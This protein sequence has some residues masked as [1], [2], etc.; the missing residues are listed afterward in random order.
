MSTKGLKG[1]IQSRGSEVSTVCLWFPSEYVSYSESDMER[2]GMGM[3]EWESLAFCHILRTMSIKGFV[4]EWQICTAAGYANR[5]GIGPDLTGWRRREQRK[6]RLHCLRG[7]IWEAWH[8][9]LTHIEREDAHWLAFGILQLQGLL[10]L[11]VKF[12]NGQTS[13]QHHPANRSLQP[14]HLL[15]RLVFILGHLCEPTAGLA[16]LCPISILNTDF[17]VEKGKAGITT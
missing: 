8:S 16:S 10:E 3:K 11:W 17:R 13:A 5:K 1:K 4:C 14:S 12:K 2:V 9:M 7:L 15:Y 6:W